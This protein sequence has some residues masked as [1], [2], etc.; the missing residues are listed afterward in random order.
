MVEVVPPCPEPEEEATPILVE[1]TVL[2]MS[3]FQQK[4][5]LGISA[6]LKSKGSELAIISLK[7]DEQAGTSK[8]ASDEALE[9][10]GLEVEA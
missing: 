8:G 10:R 7:I 3:H 1:D 5:N 9:D 6:S 4:K 2:C